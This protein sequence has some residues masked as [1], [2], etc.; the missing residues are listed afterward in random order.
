MQPL[1][2]FNKYLKEYKIVYAYPDYGWTIQFLSKTNKICFTLTPKG[3]L[4]FAGDKQQLTEDQHIK[5]NNM[6]V[7]KQ[8]FR[9]K[10]QY[11]NSILSTVLDLLSQGGYSY[12]YNGNI[13]GHVWDFI[14]TVVT[15][16]DD[17]TL[18]VS[19]VEQDKGSEVRT[20]HIYYMTV[21]NYQQKDLEAYT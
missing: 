8:I 12:R 6:L 5:L 4:I 2:H 11:D 15:L 1:E 9:A 13:A 16:T 10:P 21:N 7:K 14:H 17:R 19:F 20:E 3:V 18:A